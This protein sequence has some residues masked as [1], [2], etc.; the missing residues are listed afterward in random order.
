MVVI[1]FAVIAIIVL[2]MVIED[3]TKELRVVKK[4]VKRIDDLTKDIEDNYIGKF[5]A[6]KTFW[7]TKV[8]EIRNTLEE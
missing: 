4:K 6:Q 7:Y 1:L 8:D 5:D 3:L 2:L